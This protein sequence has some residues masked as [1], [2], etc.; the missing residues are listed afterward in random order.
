MPSFWS[1]VTVH[2]HQEALALRN[3]RRQ[4]FESWYPFILA[5]RGFRRTLRVCPVFPGYV[6]VRLDDELVNWSPLN[7]TLG[8]RRLL[9][10]TA[11]GDYRRP[12]RVPFADDLWRLRLRPS[13]TNQPQDMIEPGTIVRVLRGPFQERT[14]LVELSEGDRVKLLLQAFNREVTIEFSVDNV[15]LIRRPTGTVALA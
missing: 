14:G 8:V 9:T 10:A 11:N 7:S 12:A 2:P 3:I 6:F 1:C 13:G 15:Q 5:P 4:G